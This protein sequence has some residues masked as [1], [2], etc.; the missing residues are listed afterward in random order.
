MNIKEQT[1]RCR[2]STIIGMAAIALF[3]YG[4]LTH[5]MRTTYVVDLCKAGFRN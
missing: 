2:P 1:Q 4:T 5:I 3:A